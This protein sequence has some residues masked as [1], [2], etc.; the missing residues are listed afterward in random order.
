MSYCL[1]AILIRFVDMNEIKGSD[2]SKWH[3]LVKSRQLLLVGFC[4]I[5]RNLSFIQEIL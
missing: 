4:L 2:E 5:I 1:I 3:L